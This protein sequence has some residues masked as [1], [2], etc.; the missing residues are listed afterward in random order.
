[1]YLFWVTRTLQL[2]ELGHYDADVMIIVQITH[3]VPPTFSAFSNQTFPGRVRLKMALVLVRKSRL[4]IFSIKS[5]AIF[6]IA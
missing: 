5:R 2:F 3:C 1:M 6:K 4:I